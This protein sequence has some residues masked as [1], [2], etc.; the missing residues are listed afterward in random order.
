MK[1]CK[2]LQ[3]QIKDITAE[4]ES[5][6][7]KTVRMELTTDLEVF[8]RG[9]KNKKKRTTLIKKLIKQKRLDMNQAVKDLDFETAAILRDEVL[10]LEVMIID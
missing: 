9:E 10:A 5:D 4:L 7:Q 8:V 6:H 3:K 2:L 1:T